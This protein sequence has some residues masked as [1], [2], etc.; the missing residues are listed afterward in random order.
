MRWHPEV[1][2]EDFS[3]LDAAIA[4]D[5]AIY[6]ALVYRPHPET[7]PAHHQPDTVVE[8]LAP[9]IPDIVPGRIVSIRVDRD[10]GGFD[11]AG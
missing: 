7:K 4:V 11:L 9:P 8:L 10:Q 3:F 1:P 6:Q 5:G 2:P